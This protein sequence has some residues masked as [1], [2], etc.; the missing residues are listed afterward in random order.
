VNTTLAAALAETGQFA[1]AIEIIEHLQVAARR[2]SDATAIERLEA[3]RSLFSAG[4]PLRLSP[5]ELSKW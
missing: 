2:A 4:R 3:Y 5:D 1:K